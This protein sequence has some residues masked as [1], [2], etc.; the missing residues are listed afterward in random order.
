MFIFSF[1]IIYFYPKLYL[2]QLR[3]G[4]RKRLKK[5]YEKL[6]YS[7]QTLILNEQGITKSNDYSS[8]LYSW[9]SIGEIVNLD[10]KLLIY[11]DSMKVIAIPKGSFKTSNELN[12]F[13]KYLNTHKL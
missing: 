10:N 6:T 8:S 7:E 4:F 11:V 12:D 13:L 5:D 3:K 1:V 9:T 2:H